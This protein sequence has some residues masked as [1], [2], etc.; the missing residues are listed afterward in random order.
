M[1]DLEEMTNN[2]KSKDNENKTLSNHFVETQKKL[3]KEKETTTILQQRLRVE[4]ESHGGTRRELDDRKKHIEEL[5]I[6]R[7]QF[8]YERSNLAKENN[9]YKLTNNKIVTERD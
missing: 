9:S 2:F 4:Q 5:I 7:D 3:E 6:E 1:S 8:A